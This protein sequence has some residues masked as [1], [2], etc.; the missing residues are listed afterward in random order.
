MD[1]TPYLPLDPVVVR[2]IRRQKVQPDPLAKLGQPRLRLPTGMNPVIVQ[3]HMNQLPVR[4]RLEQFLQQI[5][6]QQTILLFGFHPHQPLGLRV[7]GRCKV[8]LDVLARRHH[9]PLRSR[10]RPVRSDPRIQ[11]D[12]RLVFPDARLVRRQRVDQGVDHRHSP[13]FPCL[14]P[15]ARR[16]RFGST[17][18]GADFFQHPAHRRLAQRHS[19]A[20][21]GALDEQH[22]RPR[23]T[24]MEKIPWRAGQYP[25]HGLHKNDV[26]LG[27]AVVFA[28]INQ[29]RFAKRLPSV[30]RPAHRGNRAMQ[31][32]GYLSA[33]STLRAVNH[34]Q[35]SNP[36]VG[37]A[38]LFGDSFELF[39]RPR[40]KYDP[41]RIHAGIPS[42]LVGAR[43]FYE[44]DASFNSC[45]RN[46][47]PYLSR[48]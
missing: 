10:Q 20:L 27:L 45:S 34:D 2:I 23:R 3:H 38:A 9:R 22:L 29:A 30:Q 5:D 6:E 39:T 11:I 33:A 44:V 48:R 43:P 35:I 15:R 19:R 1:F 17:A 37:V 7:H 24:P 18:T 40:V 28:A 46:A 32:P 25:T 31:S 14:A 8:T 42:G 21:P 13:A 26:R 47:R 41:S 12:V 16:Q 4:V 36:R